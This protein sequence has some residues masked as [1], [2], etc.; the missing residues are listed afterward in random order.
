MEKKIILVTGGTGLIGKAI[1]NIVNEEKQDNEEWIFVGSKEA[2]LCDKKSTEQLFEKYKPTHVI[3]LAA[4]VGGLFHNM[5][6]NLDFFRNNLH[7]ND[8]VLQTAHENNVIKVVSC[9]STCIFP[10]KTI[11]PIDETMIHNGPPHP[12]NYG[13]SYAKRLL[14][15]ANHAYLEQNNRLYTSIIP[16]NVFGPHDN[17]NPHSSHVIPGLMRKLYDL[18]KNGNTEDKIFTVLGSGKPLRQFIY[19]LDL[20]K[21][22]LWVLREYNSVE[23]IILSVD[24]KDEVSISKVAETLSKAFDFKGKI[25]Y[26]TTA[27]DGQYKKTASN[28]KLR[29]YLPAMQFTSFEN[30]IKETVNWYRSNYN[31]ARN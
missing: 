5:A 30:A 11:Y 6:H 2:D 9:L 12:S 24:E 31:I 19:S 22:I 13:Y 25:V 20:A 26:D 1:E 27:A 16:C 21:L 29:N 18:I 28:S 3:H 14:D 10:D 8:N 15:V 23:P 4:M 7:I 17:F